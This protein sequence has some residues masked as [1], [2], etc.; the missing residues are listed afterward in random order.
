MSIAPVCQCVAGARGRR[1][2]R[3]RDRV[4]C[5]K[6]QWRRRCAGTDEPCGEEHLRKMVSPFHDPRSA[7]RWPSPSSTYLVREIMGAKQ[8]QKH[9]MECE[10]GGRRR[11]LRARR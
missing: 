6:K 1:A 9:Y 4:D 5:D 7:D 8:S 10:E 2:V 3:V 11:G